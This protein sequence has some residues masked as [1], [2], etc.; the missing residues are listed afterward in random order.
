MD[1]RYPQFVIGIDKMFSARLLGLI[2]FVFM[3]FCTIILGYF[4]VIGE[5]ESLLSLLMLILA[6][7]LCIIASVKF[8]MAVRVSQKDDGS[9]KY[10][11]YLIVCSLILLIANGVLLAFPYLVNGNLVVI[12][13][14]ILSLFELLTIGILAFTIQKNVIKEA[15]ES[16]LKL[17]KNYKYIFTIPFAIILFLK[18]IAAFT[19]SSIEVVF[20]V[21]IIA[22]I[23]GII[24]R[25]FFLI[26]LSKSRRSF[27]DK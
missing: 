5:F 18:I 16:I 11:A 3:D 21:S 10:A 22:M 4:S 25:I 1:D 13:D 17:N 27:A 15:D 6:E 8:Y 23:L 2:G 7:T 20:A 14:V 19:D 12:F 9:Y 24:A 26:F